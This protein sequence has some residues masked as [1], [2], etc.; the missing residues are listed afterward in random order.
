LENNMG[1][2]KKLNIGLPYDP[3]IPLRGIYLKEYDSNY[4]KS[5]CTL[6]FIEA[7]FTIANLLGMEKNQDVPLP[8]NGL[9]K[10]GIY[11]QWNFIQ[12]Q[13]RMKFCYS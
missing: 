8:M 11:K 7:L 1:L 6:M 5:T 10:C 12:S 4:Y 3:A 2:L 9:R 13:R